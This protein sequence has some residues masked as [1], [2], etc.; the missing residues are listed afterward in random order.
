V[1]PNIPA[2]EP[3]GWA[4]QDHEPTG[5]HSGP[6]VGFGEVWNILG[7]LV[8]GSAA[9]KASERL[10]HLLLLAIEFRE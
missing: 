2:I 4:V 5:N 3:P 6:E 8:V 10:P 7:S 9:I 1:T